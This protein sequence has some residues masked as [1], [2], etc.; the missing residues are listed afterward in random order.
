MSNLSPQSKQSC[1]AVAG[2]AAAD[3]NFDAVDAR[4]W[5]ISLDTLE[6]EEEEVV[7]RMADDLY[8]LEEAEAEEEEKDADDENEVEGVDDAD[9]L[10]RKELEREF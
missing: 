4:S 3:T 9:T 10:R 5:R 6:E 8:E 1:L 2:A 7:P